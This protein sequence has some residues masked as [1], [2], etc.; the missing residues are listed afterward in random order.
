MP[1][2]TPYESFVEKW[3]SELFEPGASI[4]LLEE[5]RIRALMEFLGIRE[6]QEKSAKIV[7]ERCINTDGPSREVASKIMS[8]RHAEQ[9]AYLVVTLGT[10][11]LMTD[12]GLHCTF[13]NGD[14]MISEAL[15][16]KSFQTMAEAKTACDEMQAQ[17]GLGVQVYHLGITN[18][19]AYTVS[20]ERCIVVIND[21]LHRLSED[22]ARYWLKELPELN[23]EIRERVF[24]P[25]SEI[26][27]EFLFTCLLKNP[28]RSAFKDE[29]SYASEIIAHLDRG[30]WGKNFRFEIIRKEDND[31]IVK[32]TLSENR[33]NKDTESFG[34]T[35]TRDRLKSSFIFPHLRHTPFS[36][37]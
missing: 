26:L 16:L 34:F 14:T 3:Y 30:L 25:V 8:C 5:D 19:K 31:V 1:P 23:E 29:Q 6:M 10:K 32:H 18:S 37:N 11:S 35:L 2:G 36:K 7:H 9:R 22:L 20:P 12:K 21:V 13:K 4:C 27:S 24:K 17:M 28:L 33:A 15:F